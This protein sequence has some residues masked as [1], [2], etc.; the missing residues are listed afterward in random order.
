MQVAVSEANSL[1]VVL[2][3]EER[4]NVFPMFAACGGYDPRPIARSV[5]LSRWF[6]GKIT[7]Y[8]Y[9][10]GPQPMAV[11]LHGPDAHGRFH[12]M[13]VAEGHAVV[14]RLKELAGYRLG[15]GNARL[16]SCRQLFSPVR[17]Y[18]RT[19]FA[20]V[21]HG[22]AELVFYGPGLQ[23]SESRE[24]QEC[25]A[26]RLVAFDARTPFRIRGLRPTGSAGSV[27]DALSTVVDVSF[28][29]AT[30]LVWRTTAD[31]AQSG[32]RTRRTMHLILGSLIGG[33]FLE[34]LLFSRW[35][36]SWVS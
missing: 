19:A 14:V 21:V 7:E 8:C 15:G 4:L 16:A 31:D 17:W 35:L 24:H 29:G 10:A 22:P 34:H 30:P 23:Y 2:S 28:L 11:Q 9:Q 36:W 26:S 13:P 20:V 32:N 27:F 33:S 6:A 5:F 1:K 18:T 25:F 3:P 12:V